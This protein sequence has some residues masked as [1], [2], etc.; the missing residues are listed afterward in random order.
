MHF[1]LKGKNSIT[2]SRIILDK[3][4]LYTYINI[5]T[6]IYIQI[7]AYACVSAYLSNLLVRQQIL[8]MM[9]STWNLMN[10]YSSSIW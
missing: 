8:C 2:L 1:T 4:A 7:Y 5:Y 3:L 9:I 6:H 10:Q